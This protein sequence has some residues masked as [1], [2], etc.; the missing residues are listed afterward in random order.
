MKKTYKQYL[1]KHVSK[2]KKYAIVNIGEKNKPALLIA[3]GEPAYY[4]P[5]MYFKCTVYYYVRGKVKKIGM[6]DGFARVIQI[7][8]KDGNNYICGGASDTS[9]Q[10]RIKKNKLY[11]FCYYNNHSWRED[12]FMKW[13]K[14]K[15]Y[16]GKKVVYN[17]GYL[18]ASQY[19]RYRNSYKFKR[20]VYFKSNR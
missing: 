18:D 12:P 19:N 8:G 1:K 13:G 7:S 3:Q 4:Q 2:N 9:Y 11:R 14:S 6:Y 16:L 20:Y 15:V 5:S 10:V 17:Y